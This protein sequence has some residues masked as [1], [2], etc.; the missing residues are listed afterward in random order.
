M[1]EFWLVLV[2]GAFSGASGEDLLISLRIEAKSGS[3]IE[4]FIDGKSGAVRRG[5]GS[6]SS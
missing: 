6:A 2:E 4:K 3:E 5:V 1:N